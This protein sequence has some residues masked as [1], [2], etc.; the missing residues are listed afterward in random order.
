MEQQ[1]MEQQYQIVFRY[2]I[3]FLG[4]DNDGT[5]KEQIKHNVC[6]LLHITSKHYDRLLISSDKIALKRRIDLPQA[7]KLQ[8]MLADF[9]V[10]CEIQPC[11]SL[12]PTPPTNSK[13][14]F[15]CPACGFHKHLSSK[16]LHPEIC[17][18]CHVITAEYSTESQERDQIKKNLK[19]LRKRERSKAR[20]QA[21][22]PLAGTPP[23]TDKRAVKN[24]LMI[25][26]IFVAGGSLL[27]YPP[28]GTPL[29]SLTRF[30]MKDPTPRLTS[31]PSATALD[32]LGN[33]ARQTAFSPPPTSM[34]TEINMKTP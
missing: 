15:K 24:I 18:G 6:R 23:K 4:T 34:G 14:H 17:P 28:L 19:K 7:K 8:N 29:E 25:L 10:Y 1:V 30:L 12:S 13:N 11:K 2:S 22:G 32:P 20:A 21:P 33:N 5:E 16:D 26:A 9:G 31:P 3:S 27:L